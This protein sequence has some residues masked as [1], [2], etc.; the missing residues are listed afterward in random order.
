MPE[1][2][3]PIHIEAPAGQTDRRDSYLVYAGVEFEVK[4]LDPRDAEVEGK[5]ILDAIIDSR[6][7]NNFRIKVAK[8]ADLHTGY[9]FSNK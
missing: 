3:E 1:E 8:V 5:K 4:A 9:F 6:K 2:K 7:D